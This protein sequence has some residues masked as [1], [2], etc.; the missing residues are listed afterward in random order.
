VSF[1]AIFS[2]IGGAIYGLYRL[3]DPAA[4]FDKATGRQVVE[5]IRS[6]KLQP[7]SQGAITLPSRMAGITHNG[8]VFVTRKQDGL[9]LVYFPLWDSINAGGMLYS[10]RPL[11]AKEKRKGEYEEPGRPYYEVAINQ[12]GLTPVQIQQ[13]YGDGWYDVIYRF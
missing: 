7:N 4:F 8:Q 6:G 3:F 10:S 11:S 2:L 12:Q 9:L 13:D 5:A 1:L